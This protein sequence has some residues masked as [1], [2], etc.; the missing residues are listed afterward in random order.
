MVS[1]YIM[2]RPSTWRAAEIVGVTA[3][4]G[5]TG[6]YIKEADEQ[7]PQ[8]DIWRWIAAAVAVVVVIY[9]GAIALTRARKFM[10]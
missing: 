5:V 6:A 7:R 8:A 1:A 9:A 4:A 3:T 10:H 2:T